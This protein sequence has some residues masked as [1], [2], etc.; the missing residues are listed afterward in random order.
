VW[1]AAT[2][3]RGRERHFMAG[4]LV[5]GWAT[6]IALNFADPA[7]Y[8]AR[9]NIAR[10]E[11]GKEV[12]VTYIARLGGDAAP[13][14][15]EYLARDRVAPPA[16]WVIPGPQGPS[17]ASMPADSV[18]G[19]ADGARVSADYGER[20]QA[21]RRL[22][23]DWGPGTATDWRSWTISRARARRAVVSNEAALR[24]LAGPELIEGR[25]AGCPT[26]APQAAQSK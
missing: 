10:A 8:V 5:S 18:I 20:C 13:S 23:H 3:L 24:R 11:D 7:G 21:A 26:P 9:F 22:L 15:A 4:V 6:L 25:W 2:V 19:R 17:V 1:F 16:G 12:D 14:L